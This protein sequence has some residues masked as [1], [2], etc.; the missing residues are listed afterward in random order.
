[1]AAALLK[2]ETIDGEEVSRLVDQ[3]NGKPV[4]PGGKKTQKF[5]ASDGAGTDNTNGHKSKAP[6]QESR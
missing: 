4:H 2:H 1:V 3:A 5:V 6:T